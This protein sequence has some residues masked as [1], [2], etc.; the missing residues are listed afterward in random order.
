MSLKGFLESLR[1]QD[2]AEV[3]ELDSLIELFG[4]EEAELAQVAQGL[5]RRLGKG[6]EVKD[7][8][9]GGG[10]VK[11]DLL[12]EDRLA[13]SRRAGDDGRPSPWAVRREERVEVSDSRF[14]ALDVGLSSS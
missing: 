7:A 10:V 2:H 1:P 4:I 13:R 12:R 9:L 3:D 5:R 14:E 11:A 6:V 8:L